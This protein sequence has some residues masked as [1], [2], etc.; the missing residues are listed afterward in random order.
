MPQI[1]INEIDQSIFTRVV[2]DD[3]VKVLVPGIA[4]FGPE[5]DGTTD[6]AVTFTDVTAFNKVFGYTEPEYNPFPNDLSRTYAKQ[7]IDRGAAVTFV[8]VNQGT[9][10]TGTTNDVIYSQLKD[11]T[12][13]SQVSK[14]SSAAVAS[15]SNVEY[16]VISSNVEPSNFE[17]SYYVDYYT[18]SGSEGNYVYTKVSQFT[19]VPSGTT[20]GAGPYYSIEAESGKYV[21]YTGS[22]EPTGWPTGYYTGKPAW[23]TNTF[24]TIKDAYKY[25]FAPQI[26]GINAKY[27]GSFGNHLLV[28]FTPVTSSNVSM[29]YQYSIVTVYRAD[30][31]ILTTKVPVYSDPLTSEPADWN[32]YYKY[33]ER[34]GSAGNYTYVQLTVPTTWETNKYCYIASYDVNCTK[35]IT[36]VHKLE[37]HIVTTNPNDINYIEDV[38]FDY[39]EFDVDPT[40]RDTF[41]VA[42]SNM[43][44]TGTVSYIN[45]GFPEIALTYY[46]NGVSTYNNEALLDGGYDFKFSDDLRQVLDTGYEGITV[47]TNAKLTVDNINDYIKQCYLPPFTS[48][49]NSSPGVIYT[50]LNNIKN[51]YA[52]YSDPYIY[53]FDFITSGG[54]I[55]ENFIV[56]YLDEHGNPVYVTNYEQQTNGKLLISKSDRLS[57]TVIPS[58]ITPIHTGMRELVRTRKDCIALI[59]VNP[60]WRPEDLPQYVEYI[61]ESQCAVHSPWCYTSD[62]FNSGA[63][64]LMPPSF[65]FLYTLLSNL[66]NSPDSQKWFPPAGVTRATARVVVK[67]YYE[68]GSVLLNAWQNDTLSRVNPIMKL[69]NYG[70]VIYGQY[71]TYVAIDEFTHSALESL[72]VRLVAN[73]VKKQIFNTCLKLAFEPNNSS[74]WFKF[75]D[76]MDKYLLFMKRNDGVYDYRI[77]MDESTVTTDDINELR[78]PGKVWINPTRTAEFF[79]IDFILTEAGVTFNEEG[80]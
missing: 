13:E 43:G 40:A 67:P 71:T 70:Y 59:D 39:I 11:D 32:E 48:S 57:T 76:A 58:T 47:A 17:T 61:N 9:Q 75:Y 19:P 25:G 54:F 21:E 29:P 63:L 45:S 14:V 46:V 23:A 24:Y 35:V 2:N 22:T 1:T 79:D 36:G 6:S 50:I 78:C 27:T 72:N 3:K 51:C 41:A 66:I 60:G 64:T 12:T 49:N 34:K 65:V 56:F 53:D 52:N 42:W 68:I 30:T 33:Y 16:E 77:Q 37:D 62:P 8:R 7:L 55:N 73:C 31:K 44:N 4:S 20:Y 18:R 15:A 38:K 5:F 69:K 80:E 74:L 28:T 10:A 26:L